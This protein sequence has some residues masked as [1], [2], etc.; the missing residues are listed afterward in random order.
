MK[1]L[2]Q[3]AESVYGK[4]YVLFEIGRYE[5]T[6]QR[7]DEAIDIWDKLERILLVNQRH[8]EAKRVHERMS[9]ARFNKSFVLY[10]LSRYDDALNIIDQAL[11]SEPDRPNYLFSRGFVLLA[12]EN[13]DSA[14]ES[15]ERSAAMAPKLADSWYYMG[16]IFYHRK[17]YDRAL[18]CYDKALEY[19]D[20][21]H[22]P[23]PRYSFL[24][25]F[26]TPRIKDNNAEILY[27]KGNT[28]YEMGRYEDALEALEAAIETR[29]QFVEAWQSIG[30][31]RLKLGKQTAAHSAFECVLHLDPTNVDAWR[32]K[33]D[34]LSDEGQMEEAEDAYKRSRRDITEEKNKDD[35]EA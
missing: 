10:K 17:Q 32:C 8:E 28:L 15:F 14:L 27:C 3:S 9:E 26:P 24:N 30:N 5:E 20:T 4:G 13:P 11:E 25:L 21:L 23:F 29:A 7:Y 1:K 19:A 22:F 2:D 6:L 34:I 16:M 12:L 35:A 33:G 18:E 31:T